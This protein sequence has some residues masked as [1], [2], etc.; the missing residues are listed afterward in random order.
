M[1]PSQYIIIRGRLTGDAQLN[2]S[3]GGK[4]YI[5]VGVAVSDKQKDKNGKLVDNTT[6]YN[7]LCFEKMAEIYSNLKKGDYIHVEG[8]FE[9]SIYT[10]K[11][12]QPKMDMSVFADEII[13]SDYVG[14][15]KGK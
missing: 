13:R 15:E 11:D 1:R 14:E 4:N 3:T 5:K 10:N 6:F 8:R 12:D 2:T 7:V 9:A